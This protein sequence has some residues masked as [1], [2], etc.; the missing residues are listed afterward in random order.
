MPAPASL[1]VANPCYLA[2]FRL[3]SPLSNCALAVYPSHK[4]RNINLLGLAIV[5][6]HLGIIRD[7]TVDLNDAHLGE[8]SFEDTRLHVLNGTTYLL[9]G[10][11]L[12]PFE[13]STTVHSTIS[14]SQI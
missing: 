11:R 2:A 6:C 9:H 10:R 1:N 7:L 13:V 3:L 4:F 14:P 8:N 12:L 5:G